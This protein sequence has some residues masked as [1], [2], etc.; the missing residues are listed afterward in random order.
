MNLCELNEDIHQYPIKPRHESDR[1]SIVIPTYKNV[2][3]LIPCID[4]IIKSCGTDYEFEILLGIDCCYDTLN[5]VS[6]NSFFL[7]KRIRIFFSSKNVGPYVIKN[8]LVNVAKYENILFF[9]SDD[10]MMENMIETLFMSFREQVVRFKFYNFDNGKDH[11]DINN[12]K[13]SKRV[14]HGVFL[15]KRKKFIEMKGFYGWRCGADSE[16]LERY[17]GKNNK[18]ILLNS[19]LFYRRYHETNLTKDNSTGINSE[20]RNMYIKIIAENS[21]NKQ[22][23]DPESLETSKLRQICTHITEQ[24]SQED[25]KQY[26]VN[27][28]NNNE[29]KYDYCIVITTYNRRQMLKTLLQDIFNNCKNK[30]VKV[31][32]FDDASDAYIDIEKYDVQLIRYH[33]NNGKTN[34]WKVIDD[35]FKYVKNINARYYFYLQDDVRLVDNFFE[36]SVEIYEKIEDPKKI[37][38]GT[39]MVESQRNTPKWT[40]FVPENHGDFY[41]TQWCELF[42]VVEKKFFELL[43]YKMNSISADRWKNKPNL[44]SGVG[45]QISHR[46]LDLGYNMYHVVNSLAEHG[47]HESAMN[48][49][50]R[51]TT[52][53]I[54]KH[55]N[56]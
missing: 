55:D 16:F 52:K 48:T 22:W 17:D 19:P 21:K 15:I 8:S 31:V 49:S 6:Q 54:A 27:Y 30:S 29:I 14:G 53:L 28:K 38:L 5:F 50:D 4:S 45:E 13:M 23:N 11:K 43:E 33:K 35:T 7:D 20:T 10:I 44:G 2:Y 36:R 56:I 32:V 42:F 40:N 26:L 12:L 34:F 47:D 25:M 9:D 46:L 24:A 1:L 51:K 18:S 3:F 37:S 41:K 39:L